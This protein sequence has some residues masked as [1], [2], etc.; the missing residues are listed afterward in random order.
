MAATHGLSF[1]LAAME[2]RLDCVTDHM[3]QCSDNVEQLRHEIELVRAE[4]KK[5]LAVQNAMID[6][7]YKLQP[8]GTSAAAVLQDSADIEDQQTTFRHSAVCSIHASATTA[9]WARP[10]RFPFP[11][12]TCRAMADRL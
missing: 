11:D 6:M 7:M 9:V 10:V 5:C 3:D 2:G 4:L 1:R 8:L 12:C